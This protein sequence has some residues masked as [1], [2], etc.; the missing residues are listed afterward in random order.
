MY[1]EWL[2]QLGKVDFGFG[3][4]GHIGI[5]Q[6]FVYDTSSTK[7]ENRISP[8]VI[9]HELVRKMLEKEGFTAKAH[10]LDYESGEPSVV[11]FLH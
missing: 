1:I 4:S 6:T 10:S 11:F 5:F 2:K 3:K 9:G 8:Y 7:Y